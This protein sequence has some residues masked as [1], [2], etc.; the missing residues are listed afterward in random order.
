MD[1]NLLTISALLQAAAVLLQLAT[2]FFAFRLILVTGRSAS[3]LLI[4]GAL[5]LMAIRRSISLWRLVVMG[6]GPPL[7]VD[8]SV[9]VALEDNGVCFDPEPA[10]GAP[11]TARGLGL[12]AMEERVRMLGG[13]LDLWSQKGRGTGI[14]FTIPVAVSDS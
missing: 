4:S 2:A 12:A 9:A 1:S 13:S 8:E 6:S 14:A 5:C 3:W 11:A 7:L 10:P